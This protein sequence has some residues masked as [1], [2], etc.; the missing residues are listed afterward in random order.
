MHVDGLHIISGH[1][2]HNDTSAVGA[3]R[4][5]ATP[6]DVEGRSGTWAYP[7][8]VHEADTRADLRADPSEREVWSSEIAGLAAAAGVVLAGFLAFSLASAMAPHLRWL[9]TPLT[10]LPSFWLSGRAYGRVKR[11]RGF[12]SEGFGK[13]P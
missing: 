12:S 11:H 7:A 1:G 9:W 4:W 5:S 3:G 6:P 8:G 2:Q 10:T 13:R